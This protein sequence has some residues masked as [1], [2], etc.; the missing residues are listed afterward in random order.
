MNHSLL[1]PRA[2]PVLALVM[3][4]GLAMGLA[5]LLL[6][7]A[8]CERSTPATEA[9]EP[10]A[11]QAASGLPFYASAEFSPQWLAPGSKALKDL[12]AVPRFSF[13]NQD[14]ATITND[15]YRGKLYVV[16]F[17]FATCPGICSTV[18]L[19]LKQVQD[20]FLSD[21]Q[22]RLISHSVTPEADTVAVLKRYAESHQVVSGKWDLVTGARAR[23]YEVAKLGYFASEDLGKP[24]GG[25][26]FLHTGNILLIDNHGR[27]RGVYN[28]LSTHAM[29]ELIA[30]IR[31]LKQELPA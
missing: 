23:I 3:G 26:D 14:G 22:V 21:D 2:R 11:P 20:E 10:A 31:K 7:L 27:I 29:T 13:V 28:G 4:L 12:H 16:S 25:S 9:V 24:E 15:T 1:R 17:F 19:R 30:D 6:T 5:M 8:G 18:N